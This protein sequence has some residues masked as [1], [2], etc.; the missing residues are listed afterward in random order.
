LPVLVNPKVPVM[1]PV[2]APVS[3]RFS[4][5]DGALLFDFKLPVVYPTEAPLLSGASSIYSKKN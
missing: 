3:V 1:L 5:S 2:K 4:L